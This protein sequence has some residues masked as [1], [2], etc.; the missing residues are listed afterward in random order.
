MFLAAGGRRIRRLAAIRK[1]TRVVGVQ[2]ATLQGPLPSS[3][4]GV[5]GRARQPCTRL[6]SWRTGTNFQLAS[7]TFVI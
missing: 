7:G 4:E 5:S 3:W 1:I 2:V 6:H